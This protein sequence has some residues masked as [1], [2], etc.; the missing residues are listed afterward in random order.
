[1]GCILGG[2]ISNIRPTVYVRIYKQIPIDFPSFIQRAL[3]DDFSHMHA[4]GIP[5][6]DCREA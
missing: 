6:E 4:F 2:A 3:T 5:K 1:M